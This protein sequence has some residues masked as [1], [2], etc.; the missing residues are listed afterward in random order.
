MKSF[1]SESLRSP[2]CMRS[3]QYETVGTVFHMTGRLS[4]Q[5]EDHPIVQNFPSLMLSSSVATYNLETRL[6]SG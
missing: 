2:D 1:V 5:E 3:A 6:I 4:S